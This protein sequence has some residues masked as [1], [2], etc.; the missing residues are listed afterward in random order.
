MECAFKK[1]LSHVDYHDL[2]DLKE[3]KRIAPTSNLQSN[4][5]NFKIP[6]K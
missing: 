2:R 1:L 3:K 5:D 4:P 6:F